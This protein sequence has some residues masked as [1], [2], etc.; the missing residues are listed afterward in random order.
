MCQTRWSPGSSG[1]CRESD[2]GHQQRGLLRFLALAGPASLPAA[3][4]RASS[5]CPELLPQLV[6]VAEAPLKHAAALK[7]RQED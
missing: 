4:H 6:A 5:P 7:G 1:S 3:D 2:A